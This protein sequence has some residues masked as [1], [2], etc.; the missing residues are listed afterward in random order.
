MILICSLV[1]T[2]SIDSQ[3]IIIY[4]FYPS[5]LENV[6]LYLASSLKSRLLRL[7]SIILSGSWNSSAAEKRG[8]FKHKREGDEMGPPQ[9]LKDHAPPSHLPL[10]RAILKLPWRRLSFVLG[11]TLTYFWGKLT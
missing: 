9:H 8:R 1:G 11:S 2:K 5:K 7:A 6:L 3:K 4:L 10:V